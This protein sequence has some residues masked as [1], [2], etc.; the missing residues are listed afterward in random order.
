MFLRVNGPGVSNIPHNEDNETLV[1][2]NI[3]QTSFQ[4]DWSNLYN[5][6]FDVYVR[7]WSSY[8]LN[9]NFDLILLNM[10]TSI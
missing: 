2:K 9:M 6:K 1:I 5:M 8:P 10:K 7:Y 4:F 3:L